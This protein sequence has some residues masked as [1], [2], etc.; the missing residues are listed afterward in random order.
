MIEATGEAGGR[1]EE[2]E[3]E[4]GRGVKRIREDDDAMEASLGN[5]KRGEKRLKSDDVA[6][7]EEE[8]A[9]VTLDAGEEAEVAVEPSI[10]SWLLGPERTTPPNTST[11]E[12]TLEE[13][14][15]SDED[16]DSDSEDEHETFQLPKA[17]ITK[18]MNEMRG[19]TSYLTF[20]TLIPISVRMEMEEWENTK[21]ENRNKR[22]AS[23][24]G[25]GNGNGDRIIPVQVNGKIL[26]IKAV[27]VEQG[28]TSGTQESLLSVTDTSFASQ[29]MGQ[30]EF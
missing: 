23:G 21:V 2:E 19:H 28:I 24:T 9:L 30:S 12:P 15:A 27:Q 11:P 26:G 1:R 22:N 7:E 16:E 17:T 25:N 29:G 14:I 4:E 13:Q 18:P 20:A 5:T 10:P 6:M 8:A 3:E